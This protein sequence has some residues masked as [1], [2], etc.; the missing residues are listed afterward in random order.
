MDYY[1]IIPAHNEEVFLEDTLQSVLEQ[2]LKP[3]KVIVVNDNST[4]RTETIIDKFTDKSSIFQKLNIHSSDDHMPGSKVINAFNAG[5]QLLDENYDFIVKL[6]AD[7]ILPDNY[8]EKIGYVFKGRPQ[9]GIAGGFIYERDNNDEWKLNHS[10]NKNHVRG[11]LKAYSKKCYK[12]IGGLKNAMGWDTLDELLAQYYGYEVLTDDSLKVKHLRPTGNAYN[13]QARYLQGRAMYTMRYGLWIT[14]IASLKMAWKLKKKSIF[15][16][17]M[18]GFF[19][20]Q[21]NKVPYLVSD[22][23]GKFIRKLRWKGIR[24][25]LTP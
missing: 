6:D 11:A 25:R 5:F 17:N 23:E 10:M 12:D 4:D 2:T 1:I 16:D 3:K 13:A 8:F 22:S 21:K 9:I 14:T 7:I 20:A 24:E 15:I 18:Y 19:E